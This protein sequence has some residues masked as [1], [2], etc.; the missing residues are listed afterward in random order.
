LLLIWLS[1]MLWRCVA[2]IVVLGVLGSLGDEGPYKFNSL[3]GMSQPSSFAQYTGYIVVNQ[4][5]GT[6]LWY[7]F[8]ESQGDPSTDPLVLWMTGGPGCSS[9][10]AIFYENGPFQLMDNGTGGIAVTPNPY[11]WNINSNI[12]YIDQPA[13]TGF[14]EVGKVAGYVHNEYQMATEMYIFL[15]GWLNTFPEYIGRPFFL[16]GESYAGHYVPSLGYAIIMENQNPNNIYIPLKSI[17]VG[18][19]MTSPIIQYGSY[20][21]YATAHALIDKQV[22]EQVSAQYQK[23]YSDLSSGS[24]DAEVSCN[25]IL[26]MISNA[27]GPFNEYDVTKTCTPGLPLCYNFTLATIYLNQPDVQATLHVNKKWEMCSNIV[28]QEMSKD[29][30]SRQDYLVPDILAAGVGVN[31][32]DGIDGYICNFIGQTMWTN[33][34]N[35]PHQQDFLNSP[36]EIW[37][38]NELIAGYRQNAYNLSMIAVNNAGH[39]VPMDQPANAF[40]MFTRILNNESFATQQF[41]AKKR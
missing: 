37:Y 7:W 20:G 32:Y 30:W 12:I 3:P 40:D 15:Q 36:R 23:C 29:W 39:M 13:G 25:T 24:S 26:S 34:L 1:M 35:W 16:F 18:N 27:A 8:F 21:P 33:Q 11:S 19:G 31:I 17:S 14:S 9:E 5:Y 22:D 38:V 2:L 41:G 4:T 28:H 6:Q 10:L